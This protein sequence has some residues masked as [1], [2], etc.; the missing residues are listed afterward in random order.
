MELLSLELNENENHEVFNN[1]KIITNLDESDIN[2]E[3]SSTD[4]GNIRIR[5]FTDNKA[6]KK[7]Y[8]EKITGRVT[9]LL[10]EYTKLES[11]N[12]LKESYFYFDEEEVSA[13]I[14]DIEDEIHNDI[15]IQLIV[16]NKFKEILERSNIINLNGFINFR[17][18]F[19]KLYA[20]QVVERCIDSYLM[21]KE[22][23]D[24]IS[25]IKLISDAEEGE[26]D[27]ANVIFSDQKLQIYDKN[28]KKIT[29]FDNNAE[30]S[31]ELD[32]KMTYDETVINL[33][34]SVSPKKI[35]IHESKIDKKDKEALNTLEI[36]KK[37]F[38]GKI[39]ICK[40]CKYCDLF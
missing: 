14:A 11:I 36:I 18:K 12:L 9:K 21:K 28:M 17:L 10:I 26:Y 23:M 39:E 8:I 34:L 3:I 2:I 40:G 30:F 7:N 33:L 5:Y 16:K 27:V 29:Y 15:K 25:I 24:F 20:A 4:E 19:I 31:A 13:I 1:I 6:S 37:I 22:Y 35:I 32:S 38:E